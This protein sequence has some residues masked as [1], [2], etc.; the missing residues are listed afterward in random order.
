M[1]L[2]IDVTHRVLLLLI[3]SLLVLSGCSGTLGLFSGPLTVQIEGESDMNNGNAA[4]VRIYE[5]SGD[6]NFR[7]TPLSSF[8][9]NDEEALGSE[10][11]RTPH[12]VQLYP[13]EAKNI[14]FEVADGTRF[15]GVAADLREPDREAWRS[16]HSVDEVKGNEMTVRIGADRVTVELE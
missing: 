4:R 11:V 16:I 9:R 1:A 6:T 5:L 12:E 14:E 3:L 8:W 2:P 13:D 7:N 10:L 15:I